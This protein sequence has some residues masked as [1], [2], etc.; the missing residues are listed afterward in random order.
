[1]VRSCSVCQ[2]QRD[3][4]PAAP[5][6]PWKWPS[7]PWYRLHI[8]YAGPFL[9]HMWLII[10]DAHSKWLEI[11]QMSSTTST[12]T[13]Q[14]LRDVFARFG[15]PERIVTDNAPNLVS[16]EFSHFLKQNGIKQTTS[17]PYHPASNG[18]AERAVKIFKNG[19]KKMTEGSLRQKLARFLFSYRITPQSTTGVSPAELLMGR[20]L[21]S[22]LDL[23]NPNVTDRVESSQS[24]QKASH[25]KRA[26]SRNFMLGD[27]VYARSYGQGSAW[28]KGTIVDASGPHN[29]TVEVNLSGQLTTWKR[30]VDQLRKC[31]EEITVPSKTQQPTDTSA[32]SEEEE[33]ED[34]TSGITEVWSNLNPSGVSQQSSPNV[35]IQSTVSGS[36]LRHNPLR[37]RKP[38]DRLTY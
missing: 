16:T 11:F 30:H 31:F 36:I 7:R 4:P 34:N 32:V 5:L 19:M 29:F 22:V 15:L 6:I 12:A 3:N 33:E 25:D 28:V 20:K 38:P 9:G 23:L 37:N 8:D 14:C 2:T 26:Q 21:R 18:L 24:A 13:I 17:A 35:N 1:M 10:I 27:V